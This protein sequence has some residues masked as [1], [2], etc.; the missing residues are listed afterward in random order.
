VIVGGLGAHPTNWLSTHPAFYSLRRQS[1]VTF[2]QE[3]HFD[4]LRPVTIGSDVWIGARTLVLDGI[5]V[6]DGAVIAAGAVVTRDVPPYAVVG[7]VPARPIRYRF[8]D[9]VIAELLDW[10][11]W[12]L[13][14]NVLREFAVRF[15]GRTDWDIETIRCL[16][17][18][19]VAQGTV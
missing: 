10:R 13:P 15:R 12:E 18:D 11:W 9:A 2:V 5:S 3:N 7:G 17:Q 4:E 8:D 19:T 6:G 1:G 14:D 16:R